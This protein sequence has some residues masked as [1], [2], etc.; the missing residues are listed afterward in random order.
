[1][2][3]WEKIGVAEVKVSKEHVYIPD[4]ESSKVSVSSIKGQQN[5]ERAEDSMRRIVGLGNKYGNRG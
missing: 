2:S 3:Q 5:G 4:G 1:M